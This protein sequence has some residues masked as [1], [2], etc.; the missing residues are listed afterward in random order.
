MIT[1]PS[2]WG[3]LT[4]WLVNLV[5]WI[6][7]N[8]TI[9]VPII[10]WLTGIL[11]VS[12]VSRTVKKDVLNN[13]I[14]IGSDLSFLGI[15]I[16]IAATFSPNSAFNQSLF[17][18]SEAAAGII[19]FVL[20]FCLFLLLTHG[21][22]YLQENP[23]KQITTRGSRISWWLILGASHAAGMYVVLIAWLLP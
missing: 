21:Y 13:V 5:G 8:Q 1:S 4:M 17:N 3:D 18:G 10:V 9:F 22:Y 20:F 11:V 6:V 2:W 7:G 19:I 16:L 14:K 15:S 12:L 23:L